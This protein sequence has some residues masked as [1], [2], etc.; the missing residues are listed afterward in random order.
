MYIGI[1]SIWYCWVY[2]PAWGHNSGRDLTGAKEAIMS[3][4]D[5]HI[6]WHHRNMITWK[7]KAKALTMFPFLGLHLVRMPGLLQ[8]WHRVSLERKCRSISAYLVYLLN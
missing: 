5:A 4:I 6:W 7:L 2:L 1:V 3:T 8:F